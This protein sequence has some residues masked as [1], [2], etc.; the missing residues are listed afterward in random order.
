MHG[1]V[2]P[3]VRLIQPTR[4]LVVTVGERPLAQQGRIGAGGF[5]PRH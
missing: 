3:H 4:T 2:Q 5:S 1:L